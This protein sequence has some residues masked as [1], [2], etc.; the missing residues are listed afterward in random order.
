MR[1]LING[2]YYVTVGCIIEVLKVF[3]TVKRN[4]VLMEHKKMSAF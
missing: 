4:E 3:F 1:I 2:N